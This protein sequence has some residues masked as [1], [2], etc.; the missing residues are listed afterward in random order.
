[1]ESNF[2]QC[3]SVDLLLVVLFA[4]MSVTFPAC[5][6]SIYIVAT[7]PEQWNATSQWTAT[8]TEAQQDFLSESVLLSRDDSLATFRT[9]E[10]VSVSSGNPA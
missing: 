9:N 7:E 2:L 6:T 8:E 10:C 5:S 1:M 4:A 3:D